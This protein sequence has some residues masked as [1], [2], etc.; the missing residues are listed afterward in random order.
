MQLM[1]LIEA[2]AP[3]SLGVDPRAY[4]VSTAEFV[5]TMTLQLPARCA[6]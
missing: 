1:P 6:A 2:A 3:L 5:P 4:S